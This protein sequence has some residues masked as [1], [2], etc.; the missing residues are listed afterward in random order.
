MS[1]EQEIVSLLN[2]K[3]KAK[4]S[5]QK[6]LSRLSVAL[7]N[8]IDDDAFNTL[9]DAAQD[10]ANAAIT[11]DAKKL[12]IEDFPVE[13]NEGTELE[14][15][16]L[17]DSSSPSEI[18]SDG[19][20]EADKDD[21]SVDVEQPKAKKQP[22]ASVK[23]ATKENEDVRMDRKRTVSAKPQPKVKAKAK[24]KAAAQ[25]VPNHLKPAG[26]PR[27]GTIAYIVRTLLTKNKGASLGEI[28]DTLCKEFPKKKRDSMTITA[29][30][31]IYRMPHWYKMKLDKHKDDK[32]GLVYNLQ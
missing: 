1:I 8:D 23:E 21:V 18:G 32:R 16:A 4:E 22:K 14:E 19:I 31:C 25:E 24:I 12:T 10:W 29:K 11:A 27:E 15:V 2:L 20:D 17:T 7:S 9:S 6:F 3:P 28:M 13:K 30:A 5:R 26:E